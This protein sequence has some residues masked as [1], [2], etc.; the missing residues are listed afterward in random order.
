MNKFGLKKVKI[1]ADGADLESMI[2]L[3]ARP[4][5]AGFTT[6][7][8]IDEKVRC[9]QLRGIRPQGTGEHSRPRHF[10]RGLR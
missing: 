6:N 8:D 5:I 4:E 3:S 1:F 10:L 9:Q 2:A 7:P